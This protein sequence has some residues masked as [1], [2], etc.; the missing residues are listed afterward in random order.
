MTRTSPTFHSQPVVRI[1]PQSQ[2][3]ASPNVDVGVGSAAGGTAQLTY[4]TR[5]TRPMRPTWPTWGP[6]LL[7]QRW[8]TIDHRA[9]RSSQPASSWAPVPDRTANLSAERPA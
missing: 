7:G 8:A 5:P 6:P 3:G 1:E 4:P 9:A 2:P